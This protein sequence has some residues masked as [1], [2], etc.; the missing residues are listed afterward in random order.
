MK[1]AILMT[2]LLG[3]SLVACS[4][5]IPETKVPSVVLNTFKANYA[6]AQQVE[7]DKYQGKYEAEF[8]IGTEELEALYS[9]DGKQLMVKQDLALTAIPAAI[10]ASV[11]KNFQ[12]YVIDD[13]DQVTRD[14][15]TYYQVELEAKG[16][17]DKKIVM[18]A[19]GTQASNVKYWN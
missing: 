5:S 18:S 2:C 11:Q 17:S 10:S 13:I 15:K 1:P 16:K 3:L 19:D 4:N 7:W 6:S 12:A 8:K 14:G 9:A